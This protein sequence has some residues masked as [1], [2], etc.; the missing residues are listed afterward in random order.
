MRCY[1][2]EDSADVEQY[3]PDNQTPFATEV[4]TDRISED[5]T[6][7]ATGAN[8]RPGRDSVQN[9]HTQLDMS[10]RCSQRRC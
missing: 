9:I 5:G 6:E 1:N 2:L 3:S 10:R 8:V 4:I 7:E